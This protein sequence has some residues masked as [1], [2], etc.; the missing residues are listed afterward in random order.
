MSMIRQFRINCN[1]SHFS[2]PNYLSSASN[3]KGQIAKNQGRYAAEYRVCKDLNVP[4]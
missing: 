3:E 2:I 4:H 1:Y